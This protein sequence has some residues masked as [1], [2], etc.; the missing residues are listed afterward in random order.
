MGPG[1][2]LPQRPSIRLAQALS[3]NQDPMIMIVWKQ[4][5][6]I[7][8]DGS[9]Q[10]LRGIVGP[11][12]LG[13][14]LELPVAAQMGGKSS[15]VELIRGLQLQGNGV[16]LHRQTV[17]SR[18]QALPDTPERIAERLA[19]LAVGAARPKGASEQIP[20]QGAIVV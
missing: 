2:Q 16:A 10:L 19:G 1:R 6:S 11:M 12:Q 8:P 7:A 17:F 14:V 4:V 13:S 9:T 5:G 18:T 15:D 20:G 3:L